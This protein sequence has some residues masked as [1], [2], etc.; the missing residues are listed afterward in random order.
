MVKLPLEAL[1]MASSLEKPIRGEIAA[2]HARAVFAAR[3]VAHLSV[4]AAGLFILTVAVIRTG[5]IRRILH[6]GR[7]GRAG[8]I[9]TGRIGDRLEIV[10]RR[11]PRGLH[12]IVDFTADEAFAY[13]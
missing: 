4:G 9:R 13:F 5:G 6:I 12:I 1:A 2:D 3:D 10:G 8:G 11:Q 7:A